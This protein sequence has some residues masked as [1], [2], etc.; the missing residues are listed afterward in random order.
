MAVQVEMIPVNTVR[1]LSKR[2]GL[3]AAVVVGF[4]RDGSFATTS[5]GHNKATC[6]AFSAVCDQI[7]DD[8]ANGAIPVPPIDPL[9]V[10]DNE[11]DGHQRDPSA[12][13]ARLRSINEELVEACKEA[14]GGLDSEYS[15]SVTDTNF[16]KLRAA[17]AKATEGG[18]E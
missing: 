14:L 11:G 18:D 7:H 15:R 16:P 5:Y 3:D 2:H 13:L 9:E 1:L 4:R 8:I 17:I 6:S 10:R 12:E